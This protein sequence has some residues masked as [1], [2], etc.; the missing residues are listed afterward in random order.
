MV[1]AHGA[2]PKGA[3]NG[4][5]TA[6]TSAASRGSLFELKMIVVA[7]GIVTEIDAV[8]KVCSQFN[9]LKEEF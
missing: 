4:C 1:L 5:R 8:A 2:D 7:G 6:V 3:Y 9:L